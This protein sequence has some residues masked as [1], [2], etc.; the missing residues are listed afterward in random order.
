MCGHSVWLLFLISATSTE[1]LR[2]P[3][4]HNPLPRFHYRV[5]CVAS[6]LTLSGFGNVGPHPF[7]TDA[8]AEMPEDESEDTVHLTHPPIRMHSP[9]RREPEDSTVGT[10]FNGSSCLV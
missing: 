5:L 8:L 10:P 1:C 9:P 6:L 7:V 2:S 4:S 3:P